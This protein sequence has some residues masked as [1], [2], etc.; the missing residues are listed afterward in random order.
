MYR[1]VGPDLISYPILTPSLI[2]HT[3]YVDVKHGERKEKSSHHSSGTVCTE[4]WAWDLISYPILTPSLINHTVYVDVKHG[5]KKEKSSHHS[6]GTVCTERWAWDLISYP[7]LTPVPNKP[8][9]LC[10]R[11]AR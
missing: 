4:R 8:H 2:N 11:K 3:V 6:S 5:E 1:E 9:S 10:G 7:I